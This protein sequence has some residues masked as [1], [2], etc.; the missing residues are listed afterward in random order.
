LYKAVLR[1]CRPILAAKASNSNVFL[2]PPAPGSGSKKGGS[3][4]APEGDITT[5]CNENFFEG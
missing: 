2:V 3:G 4:A 5:F 1:S